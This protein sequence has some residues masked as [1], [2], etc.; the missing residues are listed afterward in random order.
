[1]FTFYQNQGVLICKLILYS[2][3][4]IFLGPKS[5]WTKISYYKI[6][7]CKIKIQRLS[8]IFIFPPLWMIEIFRASSSA[9]RGFGGDEGQ[10]KPH[11]APSPTGLAGGS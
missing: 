2:K 1:M 7:I 8:S 4:V 3:N 10:I 11:E 5:T 9:T 6:K